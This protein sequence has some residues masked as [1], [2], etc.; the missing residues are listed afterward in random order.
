VS[1]AIHVL[2]WAAAI[3]SWIFPVLY[4][5]L[6]PWWRSPTGRHLFSF[7]MMI[8]VIFAVIMLPKVFGDYTGRNMVR[9]SSY[10]AMTV[11]LW[12]H[13]WLLIA[14]QLKYHRDDRKRVS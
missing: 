14:T 12:R 3:A 10:T 9:L 4:T 7:A 13:V 6:A 2:L 1:T 5:V 11:I 8:A